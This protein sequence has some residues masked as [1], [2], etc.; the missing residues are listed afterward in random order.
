MGENENKQESVSV[1]VKHYEIKD[2]V[3]TGILPYSKKP[4]TV[5]KPKGKHS[6]RAGE[7]AIDLFG[8]KASNMQVMN[9]LMS[10]ITTIDGEAVP[11]FELEEL[12]QEDYSVIQDAYMTL[13]G[14][15]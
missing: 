3:A 1:E 13:S 2:N 10:L 7:L 12:F 14:G 11:H 9:L 5:K 4:F 8:K 15:F 6:N